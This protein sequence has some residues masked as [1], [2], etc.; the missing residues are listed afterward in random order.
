MRELECPFF[1]RYVCCNNAEGC[2]CDDYERW[3][4]QEEE[5][6]AKK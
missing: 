2:P 1:G 4:D 6:G 3:L 5:K